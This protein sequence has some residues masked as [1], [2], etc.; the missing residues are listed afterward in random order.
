MCAKFRFASCNDLGVI[1]KKLG[2]GS[3]HPQANGGLTRALL[4]YLAERA[5][6][7]DKYQPLSYLPNEVP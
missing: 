1:V 5:A 7:G 6:L 2:G 3:K 4:W